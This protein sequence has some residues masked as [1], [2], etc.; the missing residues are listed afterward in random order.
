MKLD[1]VE[2]GTLARAICKA[3]GIRGVLAEGFLV[4]FREWRVGS[5]GLRAL[6]MNT[7]W[8]PGQ[9][10]K[11]NHANG[12]VNFFFATTALWTM[13]PGRIMYASTATL[14][15]LPFKPLVLSPYTAEEK[16]DWTSMPEDYPTLNNSSGY[17]AYTN[18]DQD[19]CEAMRAN[20]LRAT[21]FGAVAGWG[22]AVEHVNGWRAEYATPIGE[23]LVSASTP[24]EKRAVIAGQWSDLDIKTAGAWGD[25]D[26]AG[27]HMSCRAA[28]IAATIAQGPAT[29]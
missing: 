27:V 15:T 9:P 24:P 10:S 21:A 22:R 26:G 28:N 25:A 12:G 18:N 2:I 11:S 6:A 8:E 5:D 20:E 17:W 29:A 7:L 19:A 13:M 16:F 1:A 3:E 14:V 23:L 4:G